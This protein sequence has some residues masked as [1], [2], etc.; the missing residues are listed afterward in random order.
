MTYATK[1]TP[2]KNYGVGH[3]T[4]QACIEQ[5]DNYSQTKQKEISVGRTLTQ[6]DLHKSREGGGGGGGGE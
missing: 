6:T 3:F 2:S 4:T 5:E 1:I